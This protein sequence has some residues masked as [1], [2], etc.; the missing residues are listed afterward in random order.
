MGMNRITRQFSAWIACF[1][2]LVAAFAP[3]ISHALS[4]AKGSGAA[5]IEICSID[6]AKLVKLG[7]EQNPTSPAPVE[8]AMHAE[9][10]PFC[11]THAESVGPLPAAEF[12]IPVIGGTQLHPLLY[13]Q[14]PRPLFIWAA[15]QSRAP[16]AIS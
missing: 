2:I 6:G 7:D 1:A 4:A 10:C 16:P 11:F 8:K 9:H 13:Y 14:S 3:S 5:W 12:I 15:A